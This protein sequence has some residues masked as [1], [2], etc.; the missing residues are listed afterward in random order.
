MAQKSYTA[1]ATGAVAG[2]VDAG[3]G[4]T[5]RNFNLKVTSQAPDS[6]VSLETSADDVE[7]DEQDRVTGPNWSSAARHHSRRY[8]RVNVINLG[9]GAHPLSVVLTYS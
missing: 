7:W 2:P 8:A 4:N 5:F 1:S 6:V 3:A 9:T